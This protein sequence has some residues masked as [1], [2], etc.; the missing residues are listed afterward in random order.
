MLTFYFGFQ[1]CQQ[2]G[3][4]YYLY[5]YKFTDFNEVWF[6]PSRYQEKNNHIS[7]GCL[8]F[9]VGPKR[10]FLLILTFPNL[11]STLIRDARL[12]LKVE[13][14]RYVLS[15]SRMSTKK[16]NSHLTSHN[17]A[18]GKGCALFWSVLAVGLGLT[19]DLEY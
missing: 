9:N 15:K 14:A 3:W 2:N 17:M 13:F 19:H 16:N 12:V 18:E 8:I 6:S 10:R 7:R 1:K 4:T 5:V 11:S